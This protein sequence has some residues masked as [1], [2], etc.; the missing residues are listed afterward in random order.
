MR[1]TGLVVLVSLGC[2]CVGSPFGG[3]SRQPTPGYQV[4]QAP[5]GWKRVRFKEND[6]AFVDPRGRFLLASNATCRGH[7]DPPLEVLTNEL[8]V[9]FTQRQ[10]LSQKRYSLDGREALRSTIRAQLDG[11]P[12]EMVLTVLKKDGCVFDF[13]YLAPAGHLEEHQNAYEQM[14]STFSTETS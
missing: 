5:E 11:V 12:V 4:G 3:P 10:E 13:T 14:V 2:A 1:A 8:L 6:L 9:G 7:G